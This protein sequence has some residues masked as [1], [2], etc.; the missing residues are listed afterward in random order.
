LSLFAIFPSK[1]ILDFDA[2]PFDEP[3][4]RASVD[5]SLTKT[6]RQ[7][8]TTFKDKRRALTDDESVKDAEVNEIGWSE[9]TESQ[10]ISSET[11]S[12]MLTTTALSSITADDE[13]PKILQPLTVSPDQFQRFISGEQMIREVDETLRGS[14]NRW[15]RI[16]EKMKTFGEPLE[17]YF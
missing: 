16:S 11:S 14:W 17:M 6:E 1:S 13:M 5:R 10:C 8:A 7:R 15:K 3:L 2:Q 12:T 4:V 9:E